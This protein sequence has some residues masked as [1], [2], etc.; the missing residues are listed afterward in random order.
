[1]ALIRILIR[2]FPDSWLICLLA[3]IELFSLIVR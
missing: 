1:V 2:R 3:S